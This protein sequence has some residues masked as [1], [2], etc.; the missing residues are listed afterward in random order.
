MNNPQN[1]I[2]NIIYFERRFYEINPDGRFLESLVEFCY[3]FKPLLPSRYSIAV[4]DTDVFVTSLIGQSLKLPVIEKRK[5]DEY[6][7]INQAITNNEVFTQ[8]SNSLG[9][10]L[11]QTTVPVHGIDGGVIGTFNIFYQPD[12]IQKD[13]DYRNELVRAIGI[14]METGVICRYLA[15]KINQLLSAD[16]VLI[17]EYDTIEE[18]FFSASEFTFDNT[19]LVSE[20]FEREKLTYGHSIY[21]N[22]KNTVQS[23]VYS[24]AKLPDIQ[25]SPF[26]NNTRQTFVVTPIISKDQIIGT[27]NVGFTHNTELNKSMIYLIEELA[28]YL[29]ICMARDNNLK[30][31][32]QISKQLSVIEKELHT[33]QD[34]NSVRD[35][36]REFL[37]DTRDQLIQ[38]ITNVG[39][40]CDIE[41]QQSDAA[42]S[43]IVDHLDKMTYAVNQLQSHDFVLDHSSHVAVDIKS[44]ID[45]ALFGME[46][47]AAMNKMPVKNVLFSNRITSCGITELNRNEFDRILNNVLFV[48]I[49]KSQ[50]NSTIYF[51][52]RE[53]ENR[54]HIMVRNFQGDLSAVRHPEDTQKHQKRSE[55]VFR[56]TKML[57]S[58]NDIEFR[59]DVF[60]DFKFIC[61][62]IFKRTDSARFLRT[63]VELQ[64]DIKVENE[65]FNILVV[66]DDD[67]LSE[68]MV[69][70]LES[71]N[72]QVS[73][74][75]DATSAI[76]EFKKHKFDLVIT[77]L[78]LPKI[79]GLELASRVKDMCPAVPVIM[80][81]GWTSEV[82]QIKEKNLNID[83]ILSKPFNLI[84]LMG[85][86]EGALKLLKPIEV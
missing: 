7:K 13:A 27:L 85:M 26:R 52:S 28:W 81:T 10:E 3:S 82:E 22:I 62:F 50:L 80:V 9:F 8:Q 5:I 4:T 57:L 14:G 35:L 34:T 60:A 11:I 29:S 84:D 78:S 56:T 74:C 20:D 24:S 37:S 21:K 30:S 19:T 64:N 38:I 51:D 18:C 75:H 44:I 46:E 70:I 47:K 59:F 77:D 40:L 45:E 86:V 42:L 12:D 49:N 48:L 72:F 23:Y 73:C 32:D 63:E 71:R 54:T 76:E 33:F 1:I 39:I 53:S 31:L 16:H 36:R 69:D 79:S 41:N 43:H 55:L 83:F 58:L 25:N 65:S 66:D 17:T 2:E 6:F 67:A 15:E 61:E 68:L